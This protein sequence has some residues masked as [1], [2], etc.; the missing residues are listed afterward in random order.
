MFLT[1]YNSIESILNPLNVNDAV[2]LGKY[3]SGIDSIRESFVQYDILVVK[4]KYNYF[5]LNLLCNRSETY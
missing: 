3:L 5:N 2:T 4:L 1:R